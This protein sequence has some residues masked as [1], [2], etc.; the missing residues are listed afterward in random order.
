MWPYLDLPE[1]TSDREIASGSARM[2]AGQLR[3][4]TEVSVACRKYQHHQSGART[5]DFTGGDSAMTS[6]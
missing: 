2:V 1:G 6:Y 5:R 4:P 3:F